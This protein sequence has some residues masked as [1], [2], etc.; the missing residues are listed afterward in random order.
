MFYE[1]LMIDGVKMSASLGNVVYPKDWL[2]VAPAE[3][4]RFLYNKKLMKTRSF[5]WRYL[6]NLYDEYDR[7]ADVYFDRVKV[8]NEKE[9]EHIKRLFE[10][11]QLGKPKAC[12]TIPF[13][14][15][16]IIAQIHNPAKSL[17]KAI[18][19]L[20]FTGHVDKVGKEDKEEIR[21][22]LMYA[23]RWA[24][25][26]A[27]EDMK[28]RIRESVP[29]KLICSLSDKEKNAIKVFA[30]DLAK[31]WNEQSLQYRIFEI[32]KENGIDVKRFFKICYQIILGKDYGPKLGPFILAV[33]KEKII[34]L[35]SE[36]GS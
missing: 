15:A 34:A 18:E 16:A 9:R 8:A 21:K 2:E 30:K 33:G 13:S 22:R 10:I 35:L 6:P 12:V 23:R 14:F 29:P 4:L 24:E 27:P 19:L 3:L 1:H 17:D 32:A 11:S 25:K 5:S 28:I 36:V 20:R 26:Y 7:H 31:E